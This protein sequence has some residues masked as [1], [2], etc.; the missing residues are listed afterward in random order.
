MKDKA[1]HSTPEIESWPIEKLIPYAKNAKKH[2]DEQ[3]KTLANLISKFGWQGSPIVVDEKGV[4][5]A[6][7][8]RRLA[9]MELGYTH[10]PVSVAKGLSAKQKQAYRIAENKSSSNIYDEDLLGQEI[11]NL[12]GFEDFDMSLLGMSDMELGDIYEKFASSELGADLE[13]DDELAYID[14]EDV[15]TPNKS[16]APKNDGVAYEQSFVVSVECSN[17]AEMREVYE[18]LLAE[19]RQCKMMTM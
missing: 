1:K 16:S 19:G 8:G 5:L 11:M 12:A 9:A 13:L 6:G 3:V 15:V 17:E 10:V 18:Q 4:I 7:H 14:D 2:D